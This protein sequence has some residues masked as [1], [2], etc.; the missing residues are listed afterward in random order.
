MVGISPRVLEHIKLMTRIHPEISVIF[1]EDPYKFNITRAEFT[2]DIPK[3]IGKTIVRE[4][5]N[6]I[7]DDYRLIAQI[8]AIFTE[9]LEYKMGKIHIPIYARKVIFNE[10]ATIVYWH[11]GSKTVVKC[12]D[13]DSFDPEVGY[14][15]CCLKKLLGNKG[16]FND[17][18]RSKAFKEAYQKWDSEIAEDMSYYNSIRAGINFIKNNS[19]YGIDYKTEDQTEPKKE[20]SDDDSRNIN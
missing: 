6:F 15:M 17:I 11:D 12:Q 13:D 9:L 20:V 14:A 1:K 4:F 16:N 10:P 19:I 7:S 5:G 18:F 2:I 3:G 8:N